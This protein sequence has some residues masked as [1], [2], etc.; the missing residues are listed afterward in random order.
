MSEAFLTFEEIQSEAELQR[1]DNSIED[2]FIILPVSPELNSYQSSYLPP[3]IYYSLPPDGSKFGLFSDPYATLRYIDPYRS[4][5]RNG[6]YWLNARLEDNSFSE[7]EIKLLEFL[8]DHRMATRSQIQRV[9][10]DQDTKKQ[11]ILKFL[12]V[13]IQRGIICHFSWVS[14]LDDGRKKPR[15]YALTKHGVAAAEKL[16]LKT[17]PED[18]RFHPVDFSTT[19]A[20]SMHNFFIDLVANELFTELFRIDRMV[21]WNRLSG[22]RLGDGR[23]FYPAALFEVIKDLGEFRLF[24]LEVFRPGKDWVSRV[25][26]RFT[27]INSAITSLPIHLRPVRLLIIADADSRIPVLGELAARYMPDAKCRYTSDERLLKGLDEESFISYD[28]STKSMKI[29]SIPFFQPNYEGMTASAYFASQKLMLEDDD[30]DE[31]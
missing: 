24:W 3:D 28:P 14:Q 22:I 2:D 18:F 5:T 9:I 8:S 21:S 16:F 31:D 11:V 10:F 4:S 6:R 19:S 15:V 30:Y 27:R 17:V 23:S 29:A 1:T 26:N 20:P 13:C 7:R 25:K 12:D